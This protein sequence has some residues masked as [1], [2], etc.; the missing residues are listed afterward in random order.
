MFLWKPSNHQH[1]HHLSILFC[2]PSLSAIALVLD[3]LELLSQHWCV[4]VLESIV[5]CCKIVL[6]SPAI[7]SKSYSSYLNSLRCK[8]PYSCYFLVCCFRDLFKTEHSILVSFL[9]CPAFSPSVFWESKWRNC[10]FLCSC[11]LRFLQIF[12]WQQVFKYNINNRLPVVR[13]LVFSFNIN[14]YVVSSG[15]SYL[16]IVICLSGGVLVV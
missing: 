2:H 7:L 8:W 1:H 4:H 13:F 15:Y 16:I 11:F 10:I 6:T 12:I 14:S 9:S 3:G 5:E